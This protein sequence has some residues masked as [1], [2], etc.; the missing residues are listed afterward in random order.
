MFLGRPFDVGDLGLG[1]F[2]DAGRLWAGDIPYGVNTPIRSAIGFSLLGTVPAASARMWRVDLAFAVESG[3]RAGITSSCGS[4]T[5]TRRRSSSP[6]RRTFK[7]RAS[8]RFRRVCSGG[9][10]RA[11]R[12]PRSSGRRTV[13]ANRAN[14]ANGERARTL[15][16]IRDD[17][18]EQRSLP[19]RLHHATNRHDEQRAQR[20]TAMNSEPV[21]RTKSGV[22]ASSFSGIDVAAHDAGDQVAE[23][24]RRGTRRP[25]SADANFAGA[26]LVTYE[27]PTGRQHSSPNVWKM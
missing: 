11:V 10:G 24:R 19:Q 23:R 26:S 22:M 14:R 6:S 18:P 1:V 5:R 17:A 9:R 27:S 15:A 3:S 13:N 8:G 21:V 2:A 7:P 25:S 16:A 12:S 20:P 4:A